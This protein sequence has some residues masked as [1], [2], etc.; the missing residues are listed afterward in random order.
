[1]TPSDYCLN[2]ASDWED[3]EPALMSLPALSS[4]LEQL[5]NKAE[6]LNLSSNL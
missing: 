4:V 1:M 3:D 6:N 2:L 5:L